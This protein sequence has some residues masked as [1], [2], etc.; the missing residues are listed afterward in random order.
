ELELAIKNSNKSVKLDFCASWCVSCKELEEI[1]FQDVQV[2]NKL[3]EFTL[4][5]A[6]VTENND[7]VKA[8][9]KKFGVVGPPALIFW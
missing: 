5:K 8:L 3:Q 2:I 1:T 6:D 7:E 4:L 9:Q